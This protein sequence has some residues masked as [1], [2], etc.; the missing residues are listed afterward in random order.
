M[1]LL[2]R[3]LLSIAGIAAG[4]YGAALLLDLGAENLLAAMA[5]LVAGVA[6]HDGVLAPATMLAGFLALRLFHGRLP[7]SIVVGAIV[8]GS[9]TL[10]AVPVLGRFG[11]RPDNPTLLD[12]DYVLGWLVFAILTVVGT[13]AALLT[14][15]RREGG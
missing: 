10:V 2:V 9:V 5:W 4:G 11:A 6:L 15:R 3:A 14:A 13:A 8:L 1:E 12:R 7:G